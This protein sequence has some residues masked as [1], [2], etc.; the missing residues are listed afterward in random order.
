MFSSAPRDSSQMKRP[1]ALFVRFKSVPTPL[2]LLHL[3][4]LQNPTVQ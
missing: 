3:P 2:P 4:N 1:P